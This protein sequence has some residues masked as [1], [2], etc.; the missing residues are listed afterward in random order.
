MSP[1]YFLPLGIDLISRDVEK[2]IKKELPC[3]NVYMYLYMCNINHTVINNILFLVYKIRSKYHIKKTY[4][5]TYYTMYMYVYRRESTTVVIIQTVYFNFTCILFL[6]C[7]CSI[8]TFIMG[9]K[10]NI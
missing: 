8:I 7:F 1:S 5:R 3:L 2:N 4:I 6:M 9:S 10:Y